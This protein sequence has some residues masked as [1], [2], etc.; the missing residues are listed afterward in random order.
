MVQLKC[1]YIYIFFLFFSFFTFFLLDL[2]LFNFLN[3]LHFFSTYQFPSGVQGP[4]HPHP[5]ARYSGTS[6]TAYLPDNAEGQEVLELFKKCFEKR[7]IFTV[8]RSVTTGQDNC[9]VWNGIH[10]KVK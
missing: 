9:V 1:N 3:F 6:R 7:L 8:G 10:H 2:L 4:E 5:G